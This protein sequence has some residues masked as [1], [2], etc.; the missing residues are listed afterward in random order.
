M[1]KQIPFLLILFR[2]VVGARHFD[3]CFPV[4]KQRQPN[5]L[6]LNVRRL[7]LRYRRRNRRP[8]SGRGYDVP[9]AV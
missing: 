2:L 1:R 4:R 6:A 5:Y 8:P 7:D 9:A 3:P